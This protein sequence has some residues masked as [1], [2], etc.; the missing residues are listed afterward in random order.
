MS[1][2]IRIINFGDFKVTNLTKISWSNDSRSILYNIGSSI[3][4]Y[5]FAENKNKTYRYIPFSPPP[6]NHPDGIS[7][8]QLS[9]KNQNNIACEYQWSGLKIYN[10]ISN[11]I[12]FESNYLTDL[13]SIEWSKNGQYIAAGG[14][15]G[16]KLII[17]VF[18]VTSNRIVAEFTGHQGIISSISWNNDNNTIVSSSKNDGTIQIWKIQDTE[19]KK[20]PLLIIIKFLFKEVK[21]ENIIQSRAD[22]VLWHPN[23]KNIISCEY[24]TQNITIWNGESGVS[25]YSFRTI[26]PITSILLNLNGDKIIATTNNGIIEQFNFTI[27]NNLIKPTAKL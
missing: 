1:I 18:D 4:R 26:N 17:I 3:F 10:I 11:R 2:P 27:N 13:T 8:Y 24:N 14:I 15:R 20:N 22:I 9:P 25:V 12:I 23:N 7:L 21:S 16:N 5:S 19:Y 6:S